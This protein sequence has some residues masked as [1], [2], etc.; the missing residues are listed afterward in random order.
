MLVV[1]STADA[2]SPTSDIAASRSTPPGTITL[3]PRESASAAATRSPFVTTTSS[4][5]SRSSSAM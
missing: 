2:K 4:F 5:C 1:R 3:T